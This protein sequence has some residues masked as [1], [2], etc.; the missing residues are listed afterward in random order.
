MLN[1]TLQAAT[2]L[3]LRNSLT[4]HPLNLA[5]Q[6]LTPKNADDGSRGSF[7]PRFGFAFASH[8]PIGSS[9]LNHAQMQWRLSGL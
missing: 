4:N 2:S 6:Y 3:R 5:D 8:Q 9:F 7:W 1:P